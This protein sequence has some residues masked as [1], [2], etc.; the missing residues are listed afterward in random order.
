MGN[1]QTKVNKTHYCDVGDMEVYFYPNE[2]YQGD[3]DD[4]GEYRIVEKGRK[5]DCPITGHLYFTGD[6]VK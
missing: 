3:S 5:G 6:F 4:K 2:K 1:F